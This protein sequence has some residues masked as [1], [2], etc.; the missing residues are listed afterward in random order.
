M[1]IVPWY[2]GKRAESLKFFADRGHQ[3]V[4]AGYYD[5][6]PEKIR[7]WLAAGRACPA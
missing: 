3:Q 6:S 2:F 5:A 4:S 1:S 7:D